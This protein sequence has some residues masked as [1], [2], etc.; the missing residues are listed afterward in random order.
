[1]A[2]NV[3]PIG[4]SFNSNIRF[5]SGKSVKSSAVNSS[6]VYDDRVSGK[7]SINV[8]DHSKDPKVA[9]ELTG[10]NWGEDYLLSLNKEGIF[11]VIGDKKVDINIK[12]KKVS[13]GIYETLVTGKVGDKVL[14][15]EVKPK[16]TARKMVGKFGNKDVNLF[17]R[18][19]SRFLDYYVDG[20][21]VKLTFSRSTADD[22]F[23]CFGR[24]GA[25]HDKDLVPV[26]AGL[27]LNSQ[28]LL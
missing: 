20:N 13:F 16:F 25:V 17:C 2:M 9:R 22:K 18:N 6:D 5:A 7:F 3:S 11:G 21:G 23:Q 8:N 27:M 4:L 12:Q 24:Y 14:E 19:V 26:L 10:K 28:I 1:M 15:L